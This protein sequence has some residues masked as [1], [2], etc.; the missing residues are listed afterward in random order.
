MALL[1]QPSDLNTAI[2][3]DV[4][5]EITRADATLIT[6]AIVAAIQEAKMY[7]SRY[8]LLQ[9]FGTDTTDPTVIDGYLKYL[10]VDLAAWQIIKLASP[11]IDYNHLRVCYE[12]AVASLKMIQSG[13]ANPEDW[14]YA[15]T[16]GET[17]PQGDSVAYSSNPK[18]CNYF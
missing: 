11:N 2:Y 3:Q 12:D 9:L 18:R 13:K 8:D 7:L 10:V 17:A 16:T 1:V 14:P 5:D 6:R 4:L 15:D